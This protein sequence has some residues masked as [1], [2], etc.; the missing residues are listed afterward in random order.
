MTIIQGDAPQQDLRISAMSHLNLK[1][2]VGTVCMLSTL[3][4]VS[5]N[6]SGPS[7]TYDLE[8]AKQTAKSEDKELLVVFTGRGWCQPCELLDAEVFQDE[9]FVQST[10]DDFLFVELDSNFGDSAEEKERKGRFDSL[11]EKYLVGGVPKA[12]LMDAD[13]VPYAIW[14]GYSE[15]IGPQDMAE[16]MAKAHEQKFLRDDLF[17][18]ARMANS[19]AERATYLHDGLESIRPYLELVGDNSDDALFPFYETQVAS[20]IESSHESGRELRA[21]YSARKA[22]SNSRIARHISAGTRNEKLAKFAEAKDYRGAIEYIEG[23]LDNAT[24][25]D[26]FWMLELWRH[27][28]LEAAGDFEKAIEISQRLAKSDAIPNRVLEQIR[29]SEA[30]CLASAE[31]LPEAVA[32]YERRLKAAKEDAKKYQRLLYSKADLMV[33]FG[34]NQDTVATWRD[35]REFAKPRSFEWLTGT[36]F[37]ARGLLKSKE[38]DDAA[39]FFHQIIDTLDAGR[40]GEVELTWPWSADSGH[41]IMLEAA[42]C[43]LALGQLDD[44]T[45]LV[46]R[47]AVSVDR[48]TNSPR[49]GDNKDGTRL[50]EMVSALRKKIGKT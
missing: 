1:S 10:K 4:V 13:G 2:V 41:F 12:I 18:K 6:D 21:N 32:Q 30:R 27:G 33:R 45:A 19:E 16:M 14:S 5:A 11:K 7:W 50:Q 28:Y 38:Y 9:D 3:S 39:S 35:Y 25:A 8:E 20:I 31:R 23:L 15:D 34:T 37:A 47:A 44:A 42:E 49:A 17:E 40:R 48:L 24:D 36:A 46:D 43:H 29:E 26:D 22:K